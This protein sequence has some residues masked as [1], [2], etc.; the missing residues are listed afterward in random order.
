MLSALIEVSGVTL[1]EGQPG[2]RDKGATYLK[3]SDSGH[4]E[5]R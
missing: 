3:E 2:F 1:K 5:D 4:E